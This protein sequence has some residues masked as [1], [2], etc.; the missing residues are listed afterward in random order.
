MKAKTGKTREQK[1]LENIVRIAKNREFYSK[2]KLNYIV[3]LAHAGLGKVKT[4]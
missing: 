4:R 2:G 1:A 3:G